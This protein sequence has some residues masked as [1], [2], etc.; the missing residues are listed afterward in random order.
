MALEEPEIVKQGSKFGVKLRATAPSLHIMQVDIDAEVSPIMGA[1]QQSEE[2]VKKML[3]EFEGNP[4][5]IWQTDMF[6]KSM[7]TLVN[8]GLNNK[9]SAMPEDAQKK[10]RKTLSRIVNEGKGGVIC[11]L[12]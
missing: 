4:K 5:G 12:L 2:M 7:H 10:M 9:L 1:E 8:E 11:I 6:G 3:G